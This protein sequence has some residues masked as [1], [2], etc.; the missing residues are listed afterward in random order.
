M[1]A[2]DELKRFGIEPKVAL[3]SHSN[4]GSASSASSRRMRDAR[5]ILRIKAPDLSAM[6]KCTVIRHFHRRSV[7]ACI[8]TPLCMAKPICW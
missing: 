4:F 3:L 5:D 7:T 1:M 2:A 8:P 6:V